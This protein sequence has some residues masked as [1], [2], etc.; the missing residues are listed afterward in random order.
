VTRRRARHR[1]AAEACHTG[2]HAR[3]RLTPEVRRAELIDAAL[4]VL[5]QHGS[6]ASRVEDVTAAAGAAKGTFY[7]YFP[8]W[9]DLL[10]AVRDR[11]F[12]EY[13]AVVRTQLADPRHVDWWALLDAECVRFVDFI[14]ELGGLHDAIFHGPITYRPIDDTRSATKLVA[15]LLRA[16]IAAGAFAPVDIEPSAQLL[17]AA[18]HT[19]ADAIAQGGDR[20]RFLQA[21]R[22]L[23]HR[24]LLPDPSDPC[25]RADHY[26][27][28]G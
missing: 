19:T 18:L 3:R 6:V 13:A 5:K 24:W 4:R 2:R 8:S 16:G 20:A 9:D 1:L 12:D 21:L 25:S 11:I 23:L 26:A 17:F 10:V 28:S 22:R 7:L 15:E 27:E 14:V